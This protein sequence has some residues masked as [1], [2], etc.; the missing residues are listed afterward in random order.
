MYFGGIHCLWLL[1]GKDTYRKLMDIQKMKIGNRTQWV[2]VANQGK[3]K[4]N[5]LGEDRPIRTV[6]RNRK[7]PFKSHLI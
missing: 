3:G 6:N 4:K 7:Y 1:C 2:R 5:G